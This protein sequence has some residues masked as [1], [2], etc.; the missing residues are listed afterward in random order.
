MKELFY[1][2]VGARKTPPEICEIFGKIA[3]HLK[4]YT[5]R[6]GGADGADL[7][8][9]KKAAKKEIFLPWKGFNGNSSPLYNIP[10]GAFDIAEKFHPRW[11]YLREP[12]KKLMA[13][14]SM[15]VLG[16]DL[17]TNSSFLVCWTENGE[18]IGGTAQAIR[19][20][21]AYGV[22]VYNFGSG[23]LSLEK[24]LEEVEV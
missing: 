18:I 19:I 17:Q 21:N 11:K 5:L 22:P 4:D 20:A 15:Q 16:G 9:E 23:K 8:F 24:F 10:R 7:A 6:S 1:T 2:G 3:T 13:R 14:N 12:V